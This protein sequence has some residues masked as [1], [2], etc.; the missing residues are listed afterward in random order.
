MNKEYIY[1]GQYFHYHGKDLQEMGLTEKKIGKTINLD[2]REI[3]LNRT[4]GTIGYTYVAAWEVNDMDSVELALHT[5]FDDNRLSGEWFD[6]VNDD[7]V[8]RVHKM[9]S[10]LKL[11]T[12]IDLGITNDKEADEIRKQATTNFSINY[13]NKE[14]NS[15]G[16]KIL[17]D[18]CN[19]IIE[20]QGL[21]VEDH[22]KLLHDIPFLNPRSGNDYTKL[23]NNGLRVM[24]CISNKRKGL[25]MQQL[26]AKL[27]LDLT[28]NY[29]YIK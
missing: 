25:Y 28:V 13:N 26:A 5:A 22:S 4:K 20:D 9:I 24:T 15:S 21:N 23:L 3:Q 27:N 19:Q 17:I 14:Y 16:T 18:V 8:E 10:L 29:E 6:D 7:L 12:E 11:G 2:K 1:I